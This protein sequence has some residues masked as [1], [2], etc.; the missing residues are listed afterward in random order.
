MNLDF[1]KNEDAAKMAY[2]KVK[3]ELEKIYEGG[4]KKSIEKQHQK[5]KL[6]A[7][8][9]ILYLTDKDKPFVEIGAFAG[10]EMYKE[11]GGCPAAGT[12]AGIAQ[13]SIEQGK[14]KVLLK[15][16][17]AAGKFHKYLLS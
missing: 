8:E 14:Y 4:G 9:R 2:S 10:Y 12:V 6:T 15:D 16:K 5:N 13:I 17:D 11:H 7:R 1:N 3:Q